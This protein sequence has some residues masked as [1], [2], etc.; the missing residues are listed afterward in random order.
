MKLNSV[1]KLAAEKVLK[2]KMETETKF[3]VYDL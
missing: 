1:L 3:Q 2:K